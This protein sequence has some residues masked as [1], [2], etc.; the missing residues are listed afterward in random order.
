M[1]TPGSTGVPKGVML[2]FFAM[3]AAAIEGGKGHSVGMGGR[4]LSYLPL[5]RVDERLLVEIPALYFGL[6]VYF[7]EGP[8]CQPGDKHS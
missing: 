1:Y 6:E 8:E 2:S 3:A 4:I 7:S 5:S